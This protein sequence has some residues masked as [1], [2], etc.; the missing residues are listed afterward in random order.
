M[1]LL[2]G[3]IGGTKIRMGIYSLD[4]GKNALLIEKTFPRAQTMPN[5]GWMAAWTTKRPGS[6]S[7][8][9]DPRLH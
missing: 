2:V 1:A 6:N 3:D 8:G 4:K 9:C 5:I 7:R